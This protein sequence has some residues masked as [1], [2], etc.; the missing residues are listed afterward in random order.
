MVR[1]KALVV[2]SV[3]VMLLALIFTSCAPAAAPAKPAAST[4]AAPSTPAKPVEKPAPTA[5]APTTPAAPATAAIKTSFESATYTDDTY[6]FS[7]QYPKAWVKDAIVSTEIANFG[8]TTNVL[9]D[10]VTA[11]ANPEAKDLPAD[12]KASWENVPGMKQYNAI[13]NIE[14]SNAIKLADGKTDGMEMVGTSTIAGTYN[15][16]SYA[17]SFNKGGKTIIVTTYTF[18]AQSDLLKEI[19]KTTVVK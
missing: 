17:I 14:S 16:W 13:I 4:P 11:F 5:P 10:H 6:G 7:F 19:V 3:L 18:G 1:N 2:I 12:F 15:M 8:K 9:A